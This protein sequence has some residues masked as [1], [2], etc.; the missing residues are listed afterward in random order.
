M[1]RLSD[2]EDKALGLDIMMNEKSEDLCG[3]STVVEVSCRDVA[4]EEV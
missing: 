1:L 3:K 2:L 4:R